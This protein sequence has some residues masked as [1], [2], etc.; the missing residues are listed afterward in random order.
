MKVVIKVNLIILLILFAMQNLCSTNWE[1][2][3]G[4]GNYKAVNAL[5]VYENDIY[6]GLSNQKLYKSTNYGSSWIE[7]KYN[8]SLLFFDIKAIAKVKSNLFIQSSFRTTPPFYE[9][10]VSQNDGLNWNE[11]KLDDTIYIYDFLKKDKNDLFCSYYS[12]KSN[13]KPYGKFSKFDYNKNN[14]ED[15]IDSNSI[16]KIYSSANSVVKFGNKILIGCSIVKPS[17]D[18]G[19]K[20]IPVIYIYDTLTRNLQP[21]VD[22]LSD[23]WKSN[24]NC[25][26]V[27]GEDI[28][29]GTSTGVYKSTDEGLTWT[30]K[31]NGLHFKNEYY[32]YDYEIHKMYEFEGNIY[33]ITNPPSTYG[34]FN[35]SY[36]TLVY[37][38]D[39]GESWQSSQL[40]SYD[41]FV[42]DMPQD[43]AVINN[44]LL[45]STL[46]GLFEVD[47][48]LTKK[49]QLINDTLCSG[50]VQ[51]FYVD[52]EKI[53]A[54]KFNDFIYQTDI[55]NK[56]KWEKLAKKQAFSN[57]D[58]FCKINQNIYALVGYNG[59]VSTT[60]VVSNDTGNTFR[61]V[62]DIDTTMLNI[63][64]YSIYA[65]TNDSVYVA[66][67]KGIFLSNDEGKTWQRITGD[68]FMYK[69]MKMVKIDENI[70]AGTYDYG[71][72][73]SVD[74]GKS[75]TKLKLPTKYDKIT[76]KDI[77][78]HDK[79]I[80]LPTREGIF[81]SPDLGESWEK[82]NNGYPDS[83]ETVSLAS[84]GDY[85][86]AATHW[87]GSV[88]YSSDGG[89][90]WHSMNKGLS[91]R[92]LSR[93]KVFGDYLYAGTSTGL[94]KYNLKTLITSV[95]EIEKRNYL[96]SMRPYP[97][98][99]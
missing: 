66:T 68:G 20:I 42:A 96:Y 46:D 26:L 72:I 74:G 84:Y 56:E 23:L 97:Q 94:H 92:S 50:M 21:I 63:Q 83:L 32:D 65:H 79:K 5:D 36:S 61:Y 3:K 12:K 51:D 35:P 34:Y 57:V 71:L 41:V 19:V 58:N 1:F 40:F 69:V 24:V 85:I 45:I 30:R 2:I 91:G 80:Y 13:S 53:Y 59:Y 93:I 73:K 22:T 8:D 16:K 78:Y 4:P 27:K 54:T 89:E 88:Y 7:I 38:T 14:W 6:I 43:F 82:K 48:D 9:L 29:I 99:A 86:F 76:I 70:F 28:F 75:W 18:A 90:E 52:N 87:Y 60:F 47:K 44:K 25:F 39:N 31:S 67:S 15:L 62:N 10:T 37:S 17:V 64:Y 55:N 49:K 98:P 95:E 33:A 81:V 77:L 11:V